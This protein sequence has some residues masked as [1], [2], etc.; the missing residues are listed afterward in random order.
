MRRVGQHLFADAV[1]ALHVRNRIHHADIARTDIGPYV[2]AGHGADHDFGHADGQC[3]H[4]RCCKGSSA[5][6]ASRN[7]AAQVATRAKVVLK[8]LRHCSHGTAAVSTEHR[9]FALRMMARNFARVHARRRGP[10]TGRQIH[11]YNT[12]TE[13]FQT[14]ANIE[15]LA[16]LGVKGACNVSGS[17]AGGGHRKLQHFAASGRR[18]YGCGNSRRRDRLT[19]DV[20]HSASRIAGV[21]TVEAAHSSRCR[22]V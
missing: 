22:V 14:L 9:R 4:G 5:R 1:N 21:P 7:D 8:C 13:F 3:A 12:Q 19:R 11:R 20:H 18:G 17:P 6:A 16:A 2:P 10:A 15:E